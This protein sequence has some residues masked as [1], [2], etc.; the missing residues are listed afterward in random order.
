[1]SYVAKVKGDLP[2]RLVSTENESTKW[3]GLPTALSGATTL[4]VPFP[5]LKNRRKHLGSGIE[6]GREEW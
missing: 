4:A 2:L 1:M 6:M 5:F 3:V